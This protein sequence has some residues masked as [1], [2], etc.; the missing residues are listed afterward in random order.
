[1]TVAPPFCGYVITHIQDCLAD[2][3]KIRVIA[4]AQGEVGDLL[5]YLNAILPR[6]SYSHGAHA[7]TLKRGHRLITIYPQVAIIVK[8]DDED[9]AL[10]VLAWLS[11]LIKATNLNRDR[12]VPVFERRRT[13]GFLDVYRL[14]PGGN[15]RAC[16]QPTCLAFA[17]A[18]SEGRDD[19]SS[20]PRLDRE[21]AVRL[22]E[23]LPET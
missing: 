3:A 5:P 7:L 10:A 8:A 22:G 6:A 20:C 17:V 1:M 21:H 16:G 15:C 18:L 4:E 14:L 11:D 13:L 12:I 19:L 9:D 23:M 2:P